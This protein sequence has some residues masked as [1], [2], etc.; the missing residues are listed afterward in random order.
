[1]EDKKVILSL[2]NVVVKFNVRGRILTAI[3]N[4]SLD[5]YEHE[6]LAIVGESG[7][8]KSVLTKTFAGMLDSNGFIP[9]GS[10]I[11]SDDELSETD[12]KLTKRNLVTYNRALSWL[13]K[14]STLERGAPEYRQITDKKSEIA[15]TKGL[16]LDEEA[17]FAARSK[18]AS[19]DIIDKTNYLW[20]LDKK[21]DAA[22]YA[23]TSDEIAALKEQIDLIEKEKKEEIKRR[24]AAYK[25]DSAKMRDDA[26]VI[27]VL[28]AERKKKIAHP[29]VE[30]TADNKLGLV[31]AVLE[32]NDRIA[33]EIVL[34]IGR[35]PYRKQL[36][37]LAK[38]KKAFK[39]AMTQGEDLEDKNVL[40]K[41]FEVV[42]FRV[43]LKRYDEETKMLYGYAILDCAK[44]KYTNDWQQIR[45]RRIAT[46]FQD[47]MTS[48]NPVI[49]IGKQI[50]TVIL[51]HQKCSKSEA[52]K[53]TL[54]IMEKV[55]IPD[56]EKRFDDY[57]FEYSGGMRQRIV[58]AIALSCQPKILICD[59][60]TTALDVTIQ[61]QILKLI[62]DLQRD[63][64]FTTV[65]IT[66][67]LG[68]VANVAERVA[69]LYAGQIVELGSVE[70]IFYDPRHPYT[71]ALLSSL[72]QLCEKGTD[73]FSIPGTPPSLYNK[74]IGD[75]FAQR[76]EY[77]MA[78]D[79]VE[80]PPMFKI[81]D[82]HYA[83]TWLLDERAPKTEAPENIRDLHNKIS[84]SYIGFDE[85]AEAEK[86]AGND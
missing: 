27:S 33:K 30:P 42:A 54:D 78:I 51:K 37:F 34:S 43:E 45:G 9:E 61:A 6:S 18:E 40:N 29:D 46:V 64:G 74:L 66:H 62:K 58:I 12:V 56:P 44:I 14:Y 16:S 52:K 65:Y 4:V 70:D 48:L 1:M 86:E 23:K 35:Y 38:L 15:H 71:W 21:A 32:R 20:T 10:I 2:R 25:S 26:S 13:N 72:P 81:S 17:D 47:P 67:D 7:S 3:R 76:S 24:L 11:F 77:A 75:A 79:M 84:R 5:I 83:K 68:V 60:P 80:E 39:I 22:E 69:V 57:P 53:R 8:G 50:M 59:E 41:I 73:L 55:G 31:P 28:E 85:E 63:L 82:T 36:M 19:D 49:T